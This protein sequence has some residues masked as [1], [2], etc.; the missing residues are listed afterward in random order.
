M[1]PSLGAYIIFIFV[2]DN[3]QYDTY[4]S[5]NHTLTVM[6]GSS[7]FWLTLILTVMTMFTFDKYLLQMKYSKENLLNYLKLQARTNKKIDT[8]EVN[9][10]IKNKQ[11]FRTNTLLNYEL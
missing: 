3:L 2:I 1:I 5:I 11:L 8:N 6:L 9:L 10:L 7:N 4:S